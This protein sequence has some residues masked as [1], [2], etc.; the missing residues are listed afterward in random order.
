MS[1][2]LESKQNMITSLVEMVSQSHYTMLARSDDSEF[3]TMG[4]L[5]SNVFTQ[6]LQTLEEQKQI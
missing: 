1:A 4:K 2:S 5:V 6:F 3:Q